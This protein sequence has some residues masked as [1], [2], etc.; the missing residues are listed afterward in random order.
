MQKMCNSQRMHTATHT[1]C[2]T[3]PPSQ[4]HQKTV[5]HRICM[6]ARP[7]CE[8]QLKSNRLRWLGHPFRM[9]TT[10]CL[11]SASFIKLDV[12]ICEVALGLISVTG[13]YIVI[14][15]PAASVT[16]LGHHEMESPSVRTLFRAQG[17]PLTAGLR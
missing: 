16:A 9:P 2:M 11:C 15:S 4:I 10:D 3:A 5:W 13:H 7:A 17:L 6:S 8:S 1:G 12:N 14:C